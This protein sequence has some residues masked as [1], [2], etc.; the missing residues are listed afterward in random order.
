MLKAF[1]EKIQDCAF[2]SFEREGRLFTTKQVF[3]LNTATPEPLV[4]HTLDGMI[5]YFSN[6]VNRE[7]WR[8]EDTIYFAHVADY[9]EVS[10][11]ST[12]YGTEKQ[13]DRLL[14][15]KTNGIRHRFGEPLDLESFIIWVQSCFIQDENT[16]LVLRTV[17]NIEQ[18]SMASYEDDGVTQRVVARTGVARRGFIDVPNPIL[19]RPYRTFLEIEQPAS[20]FVL[21]IT[22]GQEGKEPRCALHEADGGAWKDEAVESIREY[23]SKAGIPAIG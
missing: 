17:G 12:L 21:R 19:L 4:V 1:V 20:Q 8:E 18:G 15:A 16:A 6:F 14:I 11:V 9:H 22:P 5:E 2:T 7:E 13:R 3:P 10:L 23:L